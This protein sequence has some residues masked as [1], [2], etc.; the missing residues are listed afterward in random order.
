MTMEKEEALVP[1]PRILVVVVVEV[2]PAVCDAVESLGTE[3]RPNYPRPSPTRQP[4]EFPLKTSLP[5]T[6]VNIPTSLGRRKSRSRP[7]IGATDS[8]HNARRH[9]GRPIAIPSKWP[10]KRNTPRHL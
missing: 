7:K 2:D 1:H 5:K 6:L 3:K 9:P 10:I 8:V 4:R